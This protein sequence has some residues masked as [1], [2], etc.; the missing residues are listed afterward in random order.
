MNRQSFR[1]LAA[2][3]SASLLSTPFSV[4]ASPFEEESES[5]AVSP[6][7]AETEKTQSFQEEAVPDGSEDSKQDEPAQDDHSE[8][9]YTTIVSSSQLTDTLAESKSVL[10]V[11]AMNGT[12]LSDLGREVFEFAHQH[13]LTVLAL[14]HSEEGSAASSGLCARMMAQALSDRFQDRVIPVAILDSDSSWTGPGWLMDF[15]EMYQSQTGI[16]GFALAAS[17]AKEQSDWSGWPQ[18]FTRF[19]TIDQLL[20]SLDR[21]ALEERLARPVEIAETSLI[22]RLYNPNTGEHFYTL[23]A[24]ECEALAGYGWRYESLGWNTP[25]EGE[26]VYRLYNPNDGGDHHYTTS[27][28]EAQYLIDAGWRDEGVAFYGSAQSEQPVYRLYN[29]NARVNNHHFTTSEQEKN[30]L[31]AAGWSDEGIAYFAKPAWME[32][33][34]VRGGSYR[35]GTIGYNIRQA[36]LHGLHRVDGRPYVF[37]TNGNM[38]QTQGIFSL[39]NGWDVFVQFDGTLAEKGLISWQGKVYYFDGSCRMVKNAS[40]TIGSLRYHFNASGHWDN[41]ADVE[42]QKLCNAVY[43]QKGRSVRALYDYVS[44]FTYVS[45]PIHVTP[46][47]GW[48]REQNYAQIGLNRK[49][50]HCYI[51]A[52]SL[53]QLLKQAGYDAYYI[54]GGVRFV[55]GRV[56]PH[57]WVEINLDG[58]RYILDPE[59]QWEYRNTSRRF[60]LQPV[61]APLVAYVR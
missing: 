45:Y 17:R 30:A 50:G 12:E 7:S 58:A 3:F 16:T 54:E 24:S 55:T 13:D 18:R 2:L 57:G 5:T 49:Q 59:L 33:R 22:Y 10:V 14:A 43:I 47:A 40:V 44:S 23:S 20:E 1:L 6:P 46:P 19:E 37:D 38:I 4:M 56:G 52:A 32:S 27:L 21:A 51:Y 15:L 28:S 48:T 11:S 31:V 26:A 42:V 60:F 34:T 41:Q 8:P 53:A 9:V 36:R 39:D 61:G 25:L 35:L 29:P